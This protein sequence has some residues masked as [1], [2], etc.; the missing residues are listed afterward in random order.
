M[1]RTIESTLEALLAL[2]Q[3]ITSDFSFLAEPNIPGGT[4]DPVAWK[5]SFPLGLWT[6]FSHSQTT[7]ESGSVG[8]IDGK[9]NVY[10]LRL[11][12]DQYQPAAGRIASRADELAFYDALKDAIVPDD[13]NP[14]F[15]GVIWATIQRERPEFIT[16]AGVQYIG[17][18]IIVSLMERYS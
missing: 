10:L 3:G 8:S 12:L 13:G 9:D 4:I 15:D 5:I 7:R 14:C 2:S 16:Y 18:F 1:S 6:S 17:S 11:L